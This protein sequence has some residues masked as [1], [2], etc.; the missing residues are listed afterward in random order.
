MRRLYM[1]GRLMRFN[2]M[3]KTYA[4]RMVLDNIHMTLYSG[5]R[6]ALTGVNGSGKSTLLRIAA[7]LVKPDQSAARELSHGKEI[8]IGYVPERFSPLRFTA[9]EYLS[10][11]GQI[12]G[13]PAKELGNRV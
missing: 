13:I 3:N 9:H 1:D 5:D 4:G 7:G 12:A 10:H 8:I 6:I 11:M 2:H